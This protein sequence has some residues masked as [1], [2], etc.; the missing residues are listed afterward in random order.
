MKTMIT[1]KN[2]LKRLNDRELFAGADSLPGT[3]MVPVKEYAV[4]PEDVISENY[5]KYFRESLRGHMAPGLMGLS[6]RFYSS[7]PCPAQQCRKTRVKASC[8]DRALEFGGSGPGSNGRLLQWPA[9]YGHA[10]NKAGFFWGRWTGTLMLYS[11]GRYAFDLDVGFNTRSTLKIDGRVLSTPGM[12]RVTPNRAAC[13]AKG[14]VWVPEKAECLPG[15]KGGASLLQVRVPAPAPN[16][17][18]PGSSPQVASMAPAY[19]PSAF[20]GAPAA[21]AAAPNAATPDVLA[22]SPASDAFPILEPQAEKAEEEEE[23]VVA[24]DVQVAPGPAPASSSAFSPAGI[25]S[26]AAMPDIIDE[27]VSPAPFPAPAPAP[28]PVVSNEVDKM[29]GIVELGPGGHCVEVNIMVTPSARSLA[30]KYSGPDTSGK[31]TTMPG[32]VLFCDPVVSACED[33]GPNTCAN[34]IRPVEQR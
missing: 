4:A 32:Q 18:A 19:A 15:K 6:A 29:A 34:Y 31:M 1:G 9:I 5:A 33:A 21:P 8:I 7:P 14:C 17:G 2:A 27:A 16:V 24:P 20:S 28:L 12:C 11:S 26:P 10:A 23:V 30:L 22:Y 3:G 13:E 25:F